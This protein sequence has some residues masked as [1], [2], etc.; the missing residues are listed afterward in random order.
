MPIKFKFFFQKD[1]V[2]N[3]VLNVFFIKTNNLVVFDLDFFDQKIYFFFKFPLTIV[4]EG[5]LL[6]VVNKGS[7]LTVVNEGS[8]LMVVNEG[9]LLTFVN[10]GSLL[11][12]VNEGSLPNGC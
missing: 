4:N 10:E 5:S 11:K 3:V 8:L 12:V 7:L 9:S 2:M 6:T 1:K